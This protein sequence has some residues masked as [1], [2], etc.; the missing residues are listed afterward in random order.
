M[1]TI[2]QITSETCTW[3]VQAMRIAYPTGR[4]EQCRN[5]DGEYYV[6]CERYKPVSESRLPIKQGANAINNAWYQR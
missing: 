2:E 6:V 4:M 1:K 5:C 3:K